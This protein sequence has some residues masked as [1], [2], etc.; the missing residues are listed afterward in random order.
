LPRQSALRYHQFVDLWSANKVFC[1]LVVE[2]Y[3]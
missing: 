1:A 3:T 2:P